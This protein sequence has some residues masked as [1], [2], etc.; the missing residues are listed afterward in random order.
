MERKTTTVYF[1]GKNI[2]VTLLQRGDTIRLEKGMKVYA[3]VPERYLWTPFSKESKRTD[4]IIGKVYKRNVPT[5]NEIISK[6]HSEVKSIIPITYGDAENFVN[7]LNLDLADDSFDASIFEGEYNVYFALSDGGRSTHD[8][9]Y[10]NGWHVFCQ[11]KDDPQ[12]EVDFYQSGCFTAMI[13]EIKPIDVE[14]A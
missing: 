7:G 3:N 2:E 1:E 9:G 6:V 4:V 14:N 13:P 11:K 8:G 5:L 12:I 10:P